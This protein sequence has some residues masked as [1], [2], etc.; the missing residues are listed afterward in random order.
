[1]EHSAAWDPTDSSMLLFGGHASAHF[2]YFQDLYKYSQ[3]TAT[4]QPMGSSGFVSKSGHSAVFDSASNTMVIFGGVYTTAYSDELWLYNVVSDA[5]HLSTASTRPSARA[6]HSAI[7]DSDKKN[8]LMFAG[9]STSGD[10]DNLWEY[11]MP[12]DSWRELLQETKPSARSRHSSVWLGT[13]K[14]MLTFGGWNGSPLGDLWIYGWWT[15]L[16][17]MLPALDASHAPHLYGHTAVWDDLTWS[18]LVFGGAEPVNDTDL[19]YSSDLW[20]YS[21]VTSSW[22]QMATSE[23]LPRPSGRQGHAVAWDPV[24]RFM[25]AFGGFNSTYL[26]DFWRYRAV[27]ADEVPV[28]TC[29]LGKPCT[30]I[31]GEGL[32]AGEHLEVADFLGTGSF[33]SD[34]LVSEN[35]EASFHDAAGNLV[36]LEPAMYRLLRQTLMNTTV[37]F[38][39]LVVSG[40]FSDQSGRCF[41]G[42]RCFLSLHGVGLS[43][44]DTFAALLQCGMPTPIETF[45]NHAFAVSVNSSS[46]AVSELESLKLYPSICM[47]WH[48]WV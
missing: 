20:N 24:S 44:E 22:R 15:D 3:V 12:S 33:D 41:I 18:M 38:G 32:L 35:Q 1:M 6:Y 34:F 46:N 47:Y 11:H 42:S 14:M 21:F 27:D 31:F 23:A 45:A 29:W 48:L 37:T 40:P 26:S 16:W 5:W 28:R 30:L 2:R 17:M 4:W 43:A 9:L 8:M 7:W 39:F 25:Y 19:A 36:F 10:L 13:A